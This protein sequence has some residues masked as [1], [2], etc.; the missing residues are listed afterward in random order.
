MKFARN[1]F[2]LLFLSTDQ[3]AGQGPQISPA[4]LKRQFHSPALGDV[5]A[6]SSP[7]DGGVAG[8][9]DVKDVVNHPDRFTGFEMAEANFNL[10]VAVAQNPGKELVGDEGLI[11]LEEVFLDLG[12]ASSFEIIQ[13]DQT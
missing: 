9:V 8:I 4:L 5:N 10:A 1:P 12:P 7:A 6:D 13:S 2:P 11:F 3:T